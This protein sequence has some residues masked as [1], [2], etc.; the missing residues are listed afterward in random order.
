MTLIRKRLS[1]E[2]FHEDF[3]SVLDVLHQHCR[4]RGETPGIDATTLE[5]NPATKT[6]LRKDIGDDRSD[7]AGT[8]ESDGLHGCLGAAATDRQGS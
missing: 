1:A 4:L 5:A 7:G 2:V 8:S 6:I 3:R